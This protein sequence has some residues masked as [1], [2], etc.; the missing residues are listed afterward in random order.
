MLATVLLLLLLGLL[1]T[2]PI[3][4]TKIA[5]YLTEK[6]NLKYHTNINVEEVSITVFGA[7]KLKKVLIRDYKN[8]TLISANRITTNLQ[9]VKKLID[10]DLIFGTIRADQLYL[11][12][13]Y[14]KGSK[15]LNN[16]DCF[17]NA[18][19]D[20]KK[21]THPFFMNA[22]K[23]YLTRSR[24]L[25]SDENNKVQL[26]LDLKKINGQVADLKIFG[27]NV[28]LEI[29][30]LSL[31]DHRGLF[32]ENASTKFS[33]SKKQMRVENLDFLTNHS[34]LLGDIRM[35]Y[36]Q[37]DL[38]DFIN[39]V[40]FD[41][42]FKSS[43]VSSTDVRCFYKEIVKG[44]KFN[45]NTSIKGTINDLFFS[46]LDLK[47]A[48][49]S[50]IK[51]N[52]RFVNIFGNEKQKFLMKGDFSKI[53]SN[54]D[55]LTYLLPNVLGK[56]LP[57]TLR[58][59]GLF[60][61]K[62]TI[63][64]TAD[65][66]KTD[67]EMNTA[68]GLVKSNLSIINL[69]NIDQAFYNGKIGFQNFDIGSFLDR[70]DLGKVSLD[71]DVD[72]QGFVKKYFKAK[73]EGA[74]NSISYSGY[75]YTNILL[76]GNFESPFFKGKLAI[77]DPNLK[78]NF[79]G[80]ID[81]N[82]TENKYDFNTQIEQ[83]DLYKLHL[84]N[85]TISKFKGNIVIKGKGNTIDNLEGAIKCNQISYTNKKDTYRFQ[86]FELKS[87]FDEDRVRKISINSPEIIEGKIVGK[88]HFKQLQKM[89]ENAA[90]SLYTNYKQNLID[91]GQFLKYD[92]SINNKVIEVFF[93]DFSIGK[94]AQIHGII[95][96]N[97]DEFKFNFTSPQVSAFNTV[98]DKI[99]IKIDNKNP[100]FN[101]FI[102]MDS[103][104][105]KY[106]KVRDFSL[107]NVTMKD[108]LFLRT[109]FKGGNKGEDNYNLNLY[110]TIN[111]DNKNVVGIK[112]SDIRFKDY[113]WYIN[114]KESTDNKITFDKKLHDFSFENFV[115]SHENEN[116]TLNGN[117]QS[118]TNKDLKISF[119]NVD[120]T[121]I[122]PELEKFKI[123]GFVNGLINIKQKAQI[124]QPTSCLQINDLKVNS[125]ALGKLNLDIT[126]DDSFEIFDIQSSIINDNVE[127]FN[128]D[129]E[130]KVINNKSQ[131]NVD[132]DFDRFNLGILSSLGGTVI[133]KIRGFISGEAKLTGDLMNPTISGKL[134]VE[135]AGLKIPYLN[136]DYEIEN[137]SEVIVST[138]KFDFSNVALTDSKYKTKGLLN[139]NIEHKK[140]SDWKLDLNIKSDNILAIDTKDSEDAIYYGTAFIKGEA[141]ITGPTDALFINVN[142]KSNKNTKMKIP[143]NDSESIGNSS[144]VHFLNPKEKYNLRKGTVETKTYEGLELNFDLD[145]TKDAEIEVILNRETKHGMIG[146]G[147]G[148]LNL[149]I[150]TLGK[151]NITGDFLV[152]EGKYNFKYGGL[153]NKS[154]DVKKGGTIVWTGDPLNADINLEAEYKNLNANPGVLLENASF[155]K[156]V[157]VVVTIGI[158]GKLNAP[159]P[160]F[161]IDF[162]TV[163]SDFKS[164]IQTKLDDKDIRQKQ[165]LILLSTGGFLSPDGLNQSALVT[166]NLFE[167]ASSLFDDLFQDEDSKLK[168]SVAYNQADKSV[169]GLQ[170][171]SRFDVN[172]STQV[173]DRITINGK[174]GVP[175]GGVNES[176]VVGNVEIQ[177][178]VNEDGTLNLR[179][180]N[181]ENDVTYIG[182]GIGYTQGL[183]ISYEVDFNTFKELINKLTK[184]KELDPDT[185][186]KILQSINNID[187]PKKTKKSDKKEQPAPEQ[188]VIIDAVTDEKKK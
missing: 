163:S 24:Y 186:A 146:T 105:T 150:N 98:F 57:V 32:V 42:K 14:Y 60:N 172:F 112:K 121:K 181:R 88:F 46:K 93:P 75:T 94:N 62:G 12:M 144:F 183:G 74:V 17:L 58:K 168:L 117:L 73:F 30:K 170:N 81:L 35:N 89:L 3:V 130:L 104:K 15:K 31:Q 76:N 177:Y 109:E 138:S 135:H 9:D 80:I 142:A 158:K 1:L 156:K 59:L 49:N 179:M 141:T 77:D 160:D 132:L 38:K 21:S 148:S 126:G 125:V 96:S 45:I 108:T 143:V 139:G 113:F 173:N 22:K 91:K 137:N 19:E 134:N 47:D 116:I 161:K 162:P 110:H 40:K 63:N 10:G 37:E 82:K 165:A 44:Q 85:D 188:K 184:K 48:R 83:A 107:I 28:N 122:T 4:Q 127:A 7:V 90:G 182:E 175:V 23:I 67:F 50:E 100:L 56:K 119:Q 27:P 11:N 133:T 8:D 147:Y 174:L 166:S 154:F 26:D 101:T 164:E 124:Y 18:F 39:K 64:L 69:K 159:E 152:Y 145:I 155:S 115:M 123:E 120:L 43:I 153:I 34:H 71:L 29:I 86:D 167:K 87:V 25:L 55:N 5:H 149:S 95:N 6:I 176:A 68:L 136:T 151:F 131:L 92:L 128:A 2:M 99:N 140:F 61:Y 72:G 169:T 52:V 41:A 66:V 185:K 102:E 103:I 70:K 180:Y 84:I 187:A 129:G 16:L 51:G 171:T 178:R 157:P 13:K 54:Y 36:S 106:Y 97:N 65:Y 79:D 111:K 20:G 78:L 33:F 114:E 118:K 53:A